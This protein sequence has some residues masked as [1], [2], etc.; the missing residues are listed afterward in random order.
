[1]KKI[2]L[3]TILFVVISLMSCSKDD[4]GNTNPDPQDAN[5]M[6]GTFNVTSFDDY[7]YQVEDGTVTTMLISKGTGSDFI[8]ATYTFSD[9]GYLYTDGSFTVTYDYYF[10][11]NVI[12]SE[13]D[14][15]DMTDPTPSGYDYN[16][17]D[18]TMVIGE[19]LYIVTE[20]DGQNLTVTY[21]DTYMNE[22]GDGTYYLQEWKL[23]K[24]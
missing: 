1:M 13:N 21:E 20:F 10:N 19:D 15:V 12:S 18:N 17:D 11:G 9:D 4:G 7:L 2:N 22:E 6:V 23:T 24:S 8:N 14:E 16:E 3:F 5:G